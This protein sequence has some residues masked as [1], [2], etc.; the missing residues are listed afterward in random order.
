[1]QVKWTLMQLIMWVRLAF[2]SLGS[3]SSVRGSS[4]RQGGWQN[5]G[6]VVTDHSRRAIPVGIGGKLN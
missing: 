4:N 1:M 6:R 5:T 3:E 2:K